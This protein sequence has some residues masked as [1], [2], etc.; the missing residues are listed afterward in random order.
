[1]QELAGSR[2][3][4]LIPKKP[5]DPLETARFVAYLLREGGKKPLR[6]RN[7]SR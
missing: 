5:M 4:D 2:G 1:M 7:L 3:K 6:L